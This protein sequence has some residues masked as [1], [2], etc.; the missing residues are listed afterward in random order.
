MSVGRSCKAANTRK[1]TPL[2][3]GARKRLILRKLAVPIAAHRQCVHVGLSR[4]HVQ[5]LGFDFHVGQ[6]QRDVTVDALRLRVPNQQR[7][8]LLEQL[9]ALRPIQ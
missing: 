7:A 8:Q 4:G 1:L 6:S 2:D 5:P 3:I 9:R